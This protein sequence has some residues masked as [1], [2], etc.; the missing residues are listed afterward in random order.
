[1]EHTLAKT[2][3]VTKVTEL[4]SDKYRISINEARD[5]LYRSNIIDLIDDDETGLYG[6]S[7]LYVFSLFE[8][9]ERKARTLKTDI[10][11]KNT[12]SAIEE[13]EEIEQG[14]K[15]VKTFTNVEGLMK[16]LEK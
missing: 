1:M 2:I 9:E 16:D 3:I 8:E 12:M 7:P 6:E 4:I 15:K 10:P 13:A 14:K 11:N 5:K